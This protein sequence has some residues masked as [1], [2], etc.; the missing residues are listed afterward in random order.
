MPRHAA[1]LTGIIVDAP[2]WILIPLEVLA[3]ARRAAWSRSF[4]RR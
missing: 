2:A 4:P 1:A 3:G